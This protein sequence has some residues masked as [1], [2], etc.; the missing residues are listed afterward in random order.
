MAEIDFAFAR[1]ERVGYVSDPVE[2]LLRDSYSSLRS[3]RDH[4][5]K[6]PYRQIQKRRFSSFPSFYSNTLGLGDSPYDQR[7]AVPYTDLL[8][9]GR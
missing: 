5:Y 8:F 3:L 1:Y 7:L 6:R 9:N 2:L 4:G